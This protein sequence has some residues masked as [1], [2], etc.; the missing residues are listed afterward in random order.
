MPAYGSKALRGLLLRIHEGQSVVSGD[1]VPVFE[2][3]L[4]MGF[5][6]HDGAIEGGYK[7]VCTTREG[8]IQVLTGQ[9]HPSADLG[10]S[11]DR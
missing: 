1:D 8:D 3:L 7:G 5:V 6:F 4:Q 9:L 2:R 11:N 10:S